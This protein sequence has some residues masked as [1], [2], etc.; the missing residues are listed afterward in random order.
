[1]S[2]EVK[3]NNKF[4]T[5]DMIYVALG[6]AILAV[7]AWISIPIGQIPIT[8]QTMGICLVAG[9]FRTKRGLMSVVVYILLGI[10]GVPVFSGFKSGLGVI[11]G[12]T[13]GYIV[14]FIFSALIVGLFSEKLGSKVWV[15]ALSMALGI[16]AC[17]AF[18]SA[19]F[20][21]YMHTKSAV[22][23]SYVLG[24]CVV[25]YII[26]DIVKIAV[27]CLLVNRLGKFVK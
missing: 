16:T 4:K 25:P 2:K 11:A 10:V 12:P 8:L 14:G 18:G 13:G 1:M 23:L 9:L 5:I 27:S 26:P 21:I 19:W 17:Y 6:S 15:L 22:T 24:L 3:S 20:Y 7:C